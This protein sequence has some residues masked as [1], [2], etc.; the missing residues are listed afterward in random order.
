[1][2]EGGDVRQLLE[3]AARERASRLDL[4]VAAGTLS[5]RRRN[6]WERELEG[7]AVFA[8]LA[9][10]SGSSE[11]RFEDVARE[12]AKQ[13]SALKEQ[14]AW[15]E[16]R[17]ARAFGFV[18][19]SFGDAQEMLVF[20]TELTSR[21]GSARYLAQYGSPAYFEHNTDMILSE[22]QRELRRRVEDLDIQ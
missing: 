6:V 7:L 13:G 16:E 21:S 3:E 18:E 22:R 15:V 10:G 14:A 9:E 5:K 19:A 4:S 11:A 8:R 12:F 17:L 2:E 20:T 1:M